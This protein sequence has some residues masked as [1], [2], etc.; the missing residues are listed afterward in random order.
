MRSSARAPT[1]TPP[2]QLTPAI[3]D[4]R[5]FEERLERGVRDGTFLVLT[6]APKYHE[7]ALIELA[8]RFDVAVMSFETLLLR[9]LREEADRARVRWDKVLSADATP[10][11]GS[12]FARLRMLVG[13]TR[14]QLEA[15][16]AQ[17]GKTV[18]LTH[19]GLIA[20]YGLLDLLQSLKDRVDRGP[21]G[22]GPHGLLLLIPSDEQS[23]QPTI[24]DVVVPVL[25][26]SL[27]A[28]I[29]DKWLENAHRGQSNPNAALDR[30]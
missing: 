19:P 13:R 1:A 8:R 18:L 9:A 26:R 12:D 29:P 16:L 3:A 4:A 11:D 15:A 17:P 5:A 20:R 10:R 24:D 2:A 7:S 28:R 14:S 6:V 30:A 22:G 27:W 25:G 23:A 21:A